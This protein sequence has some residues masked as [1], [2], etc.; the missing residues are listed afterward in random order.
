MDGVECHM[1]T[2]DSDQRS[3]S[4]PARSNAAPL[5]SLPAKVWDSLSFFIH[6]LT[7]PARLRFFHSSP[8]S[9]SF[10]PN[11]L[12]APLPLALAPDLCPHLP[13]ARPTVMSLA[14]AYQSSH[15]NDLLHQHDAARL[16][17]QREDEIAPLLQLIDQYGLSE[18]ASVCL[19]HRHM[20]LDEEERLV[21]SRM[22][23]EQNL[24]LATPRIIDPSTVTPTILQ[25]ES[26]AD[27]HVATVVKQLEFAEH[28]ERADIPHRASLVLSNPAFIDAFATLT[29]KLG[30]QQLFGLAIRTDELLEP[31]V[32][33]AGD[34]G[35]QRAH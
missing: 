31:R 33:P 4:P 29:A 17:W 12:R 27:G 26:T 3:E 32:R 9:F 10:H 8:H 6:P 28:R 22:S 35:E 13:L 7:S 21:Y 23:D 24:T 18:A 11:L 5:H 2:S 14:V 30:V 25:V 15:Y 20:L 19:L 34:G 16:M 1:D